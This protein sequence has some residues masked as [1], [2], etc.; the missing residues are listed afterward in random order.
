MSKCNKCGGMLCVVVQNQHTDAITLFCDACSGAI[1]VSYGLAEER[2]PLT[3]SA[4]R[5]G[6]ER[7][8]KKYREVYT[9][10]DGE[11]EKS[12]KELVI[13]NNSD[14]CD[15]GCEH[16]K[17]HKSN[18][19]CLIAGCG[20]WPGSKCVPF[21]KPEEVVCNV[22]DCNVPCGHRFLHKWTEACDTRDCG[23]RVC[24]ECVPVKEN[25]SA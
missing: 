8:E 4:L 15:Q 12:E 5:D 16:K 10:G 14:K 6:L 9:L 19:G 21:K 7:A 20:C 24:V 22:E 25:E 18:N 11:G 2:M 13:C 23:D 3:L 17:A 1:K